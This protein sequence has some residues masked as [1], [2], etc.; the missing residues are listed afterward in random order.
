MSLRPA[1]IYREFQASIDP[2]FKKYKNSQTNLTN[3]STNHCPAP[4]P[5]NHHHHQNQ[6]VNYF[7]M[8]LMIIMSLEIIYIFDW[9]SRNSIFLK[10][11]IKLSSKKMGL[12]QRE[13]A[14]NRSWAFIFVPHKFIHLLVITLVF[15][16]RNKLE[17]N[18]G[19]G[20]GEEKEVYQLLQCSRE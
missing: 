8:L 13:Q 9:K 1:W 12:F 3:Q 14:L 19:L 10:T 4:T 17:V 7:I 16:L 6:Q 5:P 11:C 15:N 2:V 20:M 18:T